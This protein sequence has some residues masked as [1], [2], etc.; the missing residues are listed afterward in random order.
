MNT[1]A[2]DTYG[3]EDFRGFVASLNGIRDPELVIAGTTLKTPSLAM[4]LKD[5]GL[6]PHYQPAINVLSKCWADVRAF[7]PDYEEQRSASGVRDGGTFAITEPLSREMLRCADA[8]DAAIDV[9]NRPKDGHKLAKS[10]VGKFQGS[11]GALR[12]YAAGH[13][14]SNDY[15]TFMLQK[16]FGQGFTFLLIWVQSGHQ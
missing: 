4:G 1:I 13:A 10:T 16:G 6:D 3:H 12:W 11:S 5:A 9:L 7:L 15:D 14:E 2:T 8:M